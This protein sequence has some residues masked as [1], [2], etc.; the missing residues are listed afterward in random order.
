M[1]WILVLMSLCLSVLGGD[2]DALRDRLGN[3]PEAVQQALLADPD[4]TDGHWNLILAQACRETGDY[5]TGIPAARRAVEQLPESAP[6]RVAL[7]LNLSAKMQKNPMS[8][9]MGKK[10]YLALLEQAI[11]IDPAHG[12]AYMALVGFHTEAPSIIG[13]SKTKALEYARSLAE[14]DLEGG[15]LLEARVHDARNDFEAG[16]ETLMRAAREVGEKPSIT[17]QIGMALVGEERYREAIVWL[18]KHPDHM[19]SV[20]Q[21]A[22]TRIIGD[23][24]LE[25]AVR[26]MDHFLDHEETDAAPSHAAAWWRKGNALEALDRVDAARAA[27][28]RALELEPDMKEA[29]KSL[30]KLK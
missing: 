29:R 14:H 20:Y 7:A 26:L 11:E 28:E 9:M 6:A 23:F 17:A 16:L 4:E 27:Y 5:E 13:A 24:A 2:L 8:W 19:P 18:D 25:E 15:L 3:E 30:A 12:P 1:N 10:E 21:A 22:R